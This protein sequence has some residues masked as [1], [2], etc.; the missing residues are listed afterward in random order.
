MKTI[1]YLGRNISIKFDTNLTP[2]KKLYSILF[3]FLCLY[4]VSQAQS[5]TI[6]FV[7]ESY[8]GNTTRIAGLTT[9]GYVST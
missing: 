6:S 8:W 4:Q 1:G 5:I 3:L 9:S 7:Y 2:M